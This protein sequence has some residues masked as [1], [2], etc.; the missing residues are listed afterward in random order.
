MYVVLDSDVGLC[1]RS[2]CKRSHSRRQLRLS[3]P[4]WRLCS[5]RRVRHHH[6]HCNYC[7][8]SNRSRVSNYLHSME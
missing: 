8:T 7:K 1:S 3:K 4:L 2:G 5:P 6:R